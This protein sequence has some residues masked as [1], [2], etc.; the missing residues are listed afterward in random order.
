MTSAEWGERSRDSDAWVMLVDEAFSLAELR[1]AGRP[2]GAWLGRLMSQTVWA[3]SQRP[4][5]LPRSSR[6]EFRFVGVD[7]NDE[8]G[9]ADD[10][11]G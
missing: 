2:L 8:R 4:V 1:P 6:P 5:N 11:P 9:D 3:A 10:D 7:V